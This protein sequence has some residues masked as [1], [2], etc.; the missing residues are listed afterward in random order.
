LSRLHGSGAFGPPCRETRGRLESVPGRLD[1]QLRDAQKLQLVMKAIA[2]AA[3]QRAPDVADG[4]GTGLR[5]EE[6]RE[7]E[8]VRHVRE[9]LLHVLVVHAVR[10]PLAAPVIMLLHA[11]GGDDVAN[12][13][14]G[15]VQ[16][17]HT[18][19]QG[20]FEQVD[21]FADAALVAAETEF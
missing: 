13:R 6:P 3:G 11:S 9:Y 12:T 20:A 18:R 17:A 4:V 21:V 16:D 10:D 15:R 5:V 1:E 14:L 8:K 7:T 2:R 19:S